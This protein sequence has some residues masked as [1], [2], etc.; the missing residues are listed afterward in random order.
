MPERRKKLVNLTCPLEGTSLHMLMPWKLK[1]IGVLIENAGGMTGACA[2][3][4][5]YTTVDNPGTAY[6]E[7]DDDENGNN[8]TTH[9]CHALA[10]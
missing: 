10:R 6:S 3:V 2:V 9:P 5:M 8:R 1:Q 7:G 4:D